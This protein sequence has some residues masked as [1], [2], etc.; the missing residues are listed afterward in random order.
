MIQITA[1][2]FKSNFGKYLAMLSNETI[3]ITKNKKPIAK[4][5]NAIDDKVSMV[6]SIFGSIADT[7]YTLE[8]ARKDRLSRQ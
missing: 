2:E 1:T 3:I 4:I 5:T 8:D 7:G 6:Q